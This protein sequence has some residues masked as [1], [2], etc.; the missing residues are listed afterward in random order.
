PKG[1]PP[2]PY[3]LANWGTGVSSVS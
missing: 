1:N 3:W 2:G